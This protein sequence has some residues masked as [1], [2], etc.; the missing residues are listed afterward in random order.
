MNDDSRVQ[1]TEYSLQQMNHT[2]EISLVDLLLVFV[3]HK[4]V[5]FITVVAC[6]LA[7]GVYAWLKPVSYTYTTLIEIGTQF[8]EGEPQPLEAPDS[9]LAKIQASYLPLAQQAWATAHPDEPGLIAVDVAV[10]ANSL[11]LRLQSTAT[12]E[13]SAAYATVQAHAAESLLADHQRITGVVRKDLENSLAARQNDL[14]RVEAQHTLLQNNLQRMDVIHVNELASLQDQARILTTERKRL[15]QTEELVKGQVTKYEHLIT[16]AEENRTKSV[17]E[18]TDESRAMTLLM[19]NNEIQQNR[20]QL[21]NLQERLSV[22]IPNERDRLA[23]AIEDNQRQQESLKAHQA[24]ERDDLQQKIAENT[25]RQSE[26]RGQVEAIQLQ[27]TNLRKTHIVGSATRSI[28]PAG[29]GPVMIVALALVLGVFLGAGLIILLELI[30]AARR[31]Q[32]ELATG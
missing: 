10:P 30:T 22:G 14:A 17:N 2:D 25:R 32:A 7:G 20:N 15:E 1:G 21:L 27:I 24:N 18:A 28:E 19:I 4:T 5:F 8:V 6:L 12:P 3:R 29:P 31:R 11:L 9:A 26:L 16:T 13:K 23:K